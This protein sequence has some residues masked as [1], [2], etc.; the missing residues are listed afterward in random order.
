MRTS[1][2]GGVLLTATRVLEA[3][4]KVQEKPALGQ[5]P[6][7]DEVKDVVMEDS[8]SNDVGSVPDNAQNTEA[9]SNDADNAQNAE[10]TSTSEEPPKKRLKQEDNVSA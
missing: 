4:H 9:Q 3:P 7:V 6:S 2:G 10:D 8:Q 1:G 5:E